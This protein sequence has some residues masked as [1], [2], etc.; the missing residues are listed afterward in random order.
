VPVTQASAES[1]AKKALEGAGY[2][3]IRIHRLYPPR[4]CGGESEIL[5]VA[6]LREGYAAVGPA[7]PYTAYLKDEAGATPLISSEW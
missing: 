3:Q 2:T 5:F 7:L 1:L 4:D 6:K